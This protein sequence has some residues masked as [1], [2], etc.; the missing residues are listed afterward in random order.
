MARKNKYL[1]FL[2]ALILVIYSSLSF[3][4]WY[5]Q[6]VNP[7]GSSGND[8]CSLALDSNDIPHIAFYDSSS[9]P[10]RPKYAVYKNNQWVVDT[11]NPSS[12]DAGKYI[13]IAVDI[14]GS[15]HISYYI[16]NSSLGS[17]TY[18]GYAKKTQQSWS[19]TSVSS[20]T[21]NGNETGRYTSIDLDGN[22]KPSIMYLHNGWRPVCAS[23]F[24]PSWINSAD[25]DTSSSEDTSF[26]I[27]KKTNVK[28]G[29]YKKDVSGAKKLMYNRDAGNGWNKTGY[30]VTIDDAANSSEYNDCLA[31][32]SFGNPRI[33]YVDNSGKLKYAV[34]FSSTGASSSWLIL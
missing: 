29:V 7:N 26:A 24:P 28:H 17:T 21:S 30:P 31:L 2:T 19:Y 13:S 4:G 8:Y 1:L 18:L 10:A 34:S 9:A 23:Y 14:S 11:L 12:Y 32:D 33:I 3:A 25:I 5:I 27:D 16:D 20:G 6:Y 22:E 15:V